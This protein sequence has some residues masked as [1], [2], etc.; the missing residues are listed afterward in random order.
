MVIEV[1]ASANSL[2]A[3]TAQTTSYTEAIMKVLD[4]HKGDVA[5]GLQYCGG[6]EAVFQQIKKGGTQLLQIT[7]IA[8]PIQIHQR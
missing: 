8:V 3:V 6:Y 4:C 7:R 5:H 2:T 1:R